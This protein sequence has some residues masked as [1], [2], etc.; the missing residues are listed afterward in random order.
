MVSFDDRVDVF[1]QF[2]TGPGR[3]ELVGAF[4]AYR[5]QYGAAWLEEF[6]NNNPVLADVVDLIANYDFPEALEEIRSL[7]SQWIDQEPEEDLVQVMK[8]AGLRIGLKGAIAGLEPDLL[9]LHTALRA[10]IDRPQF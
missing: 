9:K 10:E 7:A 3:E 4:T 8:K 2:L 6:K 1:K 5:R